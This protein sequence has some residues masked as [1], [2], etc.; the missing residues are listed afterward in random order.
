MNTWRA[1]QLQDAFGAKPFAVSDCAVAAAIA[2]CWLHRSED[3]PASV[4]LNHEPCDWCAYPL[5]VLLN[6]L[7]DFWRDE[8]TEYRER[9]FRNLA[10]AV[11]RRLV[12]QAAHEVRT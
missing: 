4:K 8:D 2:Q 1:P 11:Q 6:S 12:E 3:M 10:K 5:D 7:N 9:D